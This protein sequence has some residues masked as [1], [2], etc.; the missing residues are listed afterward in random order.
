[1]KDLSVN[2]EIVPTLIN[3]YSVVVG[4]FLLDLYPSTLTPLNLTPNPRLQHHLRCVDNISPRLELAT[5]DIGGVVCISCIP[6]K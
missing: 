5:S 2:T 3:S 4:N 6:Q 1:M